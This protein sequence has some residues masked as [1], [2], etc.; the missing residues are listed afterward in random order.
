MHS[1]T[2]TYETGDSFSCHD[3]TYGIKCDSL[4]IAREN[5]K[6]I[7]E[8]YD[9]YEWLTMNERGLERTAAP[10]IPNGTTICTKYGSAYAELSLITSKDSF[11]MQTPPWCGYFE[12]LIGA[13]INADESDMSFNLRGW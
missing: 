5:L 6:R 12:H 11:K 7:K 13:V 2:V 1:I 4:E 9:Y 8:H 3:E 10:P